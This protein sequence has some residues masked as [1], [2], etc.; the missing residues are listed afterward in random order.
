VCSCYVTVT[1][2]LYLA[3]GKFVAVVVGGGVVGVGGIFFEFPVRLHT[4]QTPQS[5][6][7]GS[8]PTC[9]HSLACASKSTKNRA[10]GKGVRERVGV[11]NG[12]TW[13]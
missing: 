8:C 12:G 3:R 13:R 1:A 7:W 11:G 9:L 10:G 2:L 5:S 4:L 6:P